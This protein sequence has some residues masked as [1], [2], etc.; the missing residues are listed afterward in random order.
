MKLNKLILSIFLLFFE[1][2][3]SIAQEK[4]VCSTDI[5]GAQ[6][7]KSGNYEE[8]TWIDI[9]GNKQ[10]KNNIGETASLEKDIFDNMVY[11]DSRSNE[12]KIEKTVWIEML[13]EVDGDVDALFYDFIAQN[14]GRNN[15]KVSISIDILGKE[16]YKENNFSEEF[17]VDILDIQQYKNSDGQTA[18]L[19]KDILDRLIYKDSKGNDLTFSTDEWQRMFQRTGGRERAVFRNLINRYLY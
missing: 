5:F 10:F 14:S 11:K 8:K 15:T 2:T 3:S 12:M 6:V 17:W 16:I 18:S 1:L 9:F 7:Y 13:A 19:K 4:G